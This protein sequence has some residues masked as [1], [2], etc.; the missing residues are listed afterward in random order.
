[1]IN[2]IKTNLKLLINTF[3]FK[4][5]KDKF[6]NNKRNMILIKIM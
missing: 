1:M 3:K 5:Y 6:K 2:N 4:K